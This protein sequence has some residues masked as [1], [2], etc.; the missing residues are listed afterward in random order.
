M[1]LHHLQYLAAV[2]GR[3]SVRSAAL[4]LGVSSTAVSRG[5]IDL[6]NLAGLPL[7]QRGAAGMLLTDAGKA[8]LAHARQVLGQL[9]AADQT[10]ATL[11]GGTTTR[12]SLGVSPWIARI[13]LGPALRLLMQRRPD[14]R[15]DIHEILGAEHSALR[16]GSIDLAICAPPPASVAEFNVRPLLNY[17]LTVS[18]RPGHPLSNARGIQ[19]L[20]GQDWVL[21]REI[22]NQLPGIQ[23]F[24]RHVLATSHPARLHYARSAQV[25]TAIVR[26]TDMLTISPWPLIEAEQARILHPLMLREEVP[27]Q[28]IALLTKHNFA[29]SGACQVFIDCLNTVIEQGHTST[30]PTIRRSFVAVTRTGS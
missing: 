26:T 30:D 28:T 6:E 1:K 18:C 19:E 5:L 20:A 29:M 10:L 22:E 12:I 2:A 15:L 17:S 13:L 24:W 21:A 16:D 3:G 4:T 11:R 8:L 27:E 9:D 25:V 7:F 23:Q 14:V